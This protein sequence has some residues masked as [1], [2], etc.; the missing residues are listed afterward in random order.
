MDDDIVAILSTI[1]LFTVLYWVYLLLSSDHAGFWILMFI[2]G[3]II[4]IFSNKK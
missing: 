4:Y 1:G 2:V 3:F